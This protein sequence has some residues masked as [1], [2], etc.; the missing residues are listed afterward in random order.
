MTRPQCQFLDDYL[1]RTL[2]AAAEAS[3]RRHLRD[4][5]ACRHEVRASEEL[6]RTL[7]AAVTELEPAPPELGARIERNLARRR[8]RRRLAWA[9]SAA[10]SVL[11]ALAGWLIYQAA[12]PEVKV[13]LPDTVSPAAISEESPAL[14]QV[15]SPSPAIVIPKRG[16]HRN[17][18]IIWVYPAVDAG[19]Q[20]A[21]PEQKPAS[22]GKRS[23]S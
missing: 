11:A 13:A 18:T 3:F 9:L 16:T 19:A 6:S 17:V 1:G 14:V 7:L 22:P 23:V 15:R 5:A 8:R 20:R 12:R 4:C 21:R 2:G 10:A